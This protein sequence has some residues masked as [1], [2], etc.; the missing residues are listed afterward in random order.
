M[1][2]G[3]TQFEAFRDKLNARGVMLRVMW[4]A[5]SGVNRR[6]RGNPARGVSRNQW[7]NSPD[8]ALVSFSLVGESPR[9]GTGPATADKLAIGT[10]ILVD[11]GLDGLG[12]W[13]EPATNSI[14]DDV[15]LIIGEAEKVAP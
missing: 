15:A 2:E 4:E 11:Y 1:F 5:R 10:A 3:N 7:N 12:I 14:D 6:R 13:T 9:L 8:V